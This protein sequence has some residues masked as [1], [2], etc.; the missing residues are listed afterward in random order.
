MVNE[1]LKLM[2]VMSPAYMQ[3]YH[4]IFESAKTERNVITPD[5]YLWNKEG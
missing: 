4:V 5:P 2:E 1:N 3:Q